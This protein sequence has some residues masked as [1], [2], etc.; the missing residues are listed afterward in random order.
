MNVDISSL[1]SLDVANGLRFSAGDPV[2][3]RSRLP[4]AWVSTRWDDGSRPP[5]GSGSHS[6]MS[7]IVASTEIPRC[8][9]FPNRAW[10]DRPPNGPVRPAHSRPAT[11][12]G[13]CPSARG[14]VRLPTQRGRRRSGR[15]SIQG[16]SAKRYPPGR[17]RSNGDASTSGSPRAGTTDA[18]T[19]H[20]RRGGY[21]CLAMA[22]AGEILNRSGNRVRALAAEGRIKESAAAPNRWMIV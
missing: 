21:T 4:P 1:E 12:S 7:H 17:P 3:G 9:T 19:N 6:S 14:C 16:R 10:P 15:A 13:A 8:Q 5:C 20:A 2:S 18:S 22:E 11:P